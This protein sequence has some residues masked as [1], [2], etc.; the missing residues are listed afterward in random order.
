MCVVFLEEFLNVI[1]EEKLEEVFC[2]WRNYVA[3][4]DWEQECVG[5]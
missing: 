5:L 2:L 3:L 1:I 4:G